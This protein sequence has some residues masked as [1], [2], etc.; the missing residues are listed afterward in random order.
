M[1][2]EH[3]FHFG[4]GSTALFAILRGLGCRNGRVALPAIICPSVIAAVL[5][6]GNQPYFVDIETQTYGLDPDRL[7]GVTE[8][9]NAVIAVHA[10][11][12]PCQ[13]ERLRDLC[14]SHEIPLIEDC[15]LAQ[16]A[17][18]NGITVGNT[19]T[20][21][22]FSYGA[23]KI[24]GIGEG[25]AAQTSDPDLSA[26]LQEEARLLPA[27][28]DSVVADAM[29]GLLKFGY[30]NFY[31][32]QLE[33]YRPAYTAYLRQNC[34]S[35]L[36]RF[37]SRM[38]VPIRE[39]LAGIAENVALRLR[40]CRMYERKLSGLPGIQTMKFE[41]GTA[42]WRFN[43]LIEPALRNHI[44]RT[45]LSEG[46]PVSSWY[47]DMTAF[48]DPVSYSATPLPASKWLSDRI[49]NLWIDAQTSES[50]IER[51]CGRIRSLWP[52]A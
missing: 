32:D 4:N 24:I 2:L 16:G 13:I 52:D 38:M 15:A 41:D 12:M 48:L 33:F 21:A 11:G 49:L 14:N 17:A 18:V 29:G 19:G 25:G 46:S 10:F 42:P 40:K 47:T 35:I 39:G 43:L 45:M 26:R 20:A 8:K 5:A 50:D 6:S 44:L 30:N 3:T 23:G 36:R 9:V 37:E 28:Y 22:I 51:T 34:F 31:P 27:H 1:Q 7:A